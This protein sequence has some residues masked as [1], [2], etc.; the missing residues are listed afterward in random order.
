MKKS[1]F[2]ALALGAALALSAPTAAFGETD[3]G[4]T[5][6]PPGE[7]TLAGSTASGVCEADVA[8]I[9][10][11]VVLHDP[12]PGTENAAVSLVLSGS[13]QSTTIPLGSLQ[14]GALSGRVLWP[15]ASIDANGEAN[16]WPGWVFENGTWV[17]TTGNFA[18]TRG[19]ITA[20]IEV[21]PSLSVP[22][23]YPPAT[24]NCASGPSGE[25]LSGSTGGDVDGDGLAATGLNAAILPIVLVG[26]VALLGG[27]ALLI[28][29]RRSTRS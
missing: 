14:D 3:E 27:A 8:W 13:G 18:W 26:G 7:P 22:L 12:E 20:T 5:P 19:S 10:F 21:N 6:P 15:G 24:P 28:S 29:H 11:D 2:A 23:S 16:G 25:V 17:E 1:V 4:Y 9:N